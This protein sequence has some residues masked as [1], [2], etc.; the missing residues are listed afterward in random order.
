MQS[1]SGQQHAV[2]LGAGMAGLL[3]AR[4]L[5]DRYGLVTVIERDILPPSA[6]H[7]RGVSQGRHGH[8]LLARGIEVL[9]EL[10]PGFSDEMTARGGLRADLQGQTR[11]YNEGLLL[12]QAP[13]GLDALLGSRP[14]LE[15]LV[16]DRLR[17]MDNIR[18]TD[19][20]EAVGL[21]AGQD[22][23]R[24]TGLRVVSGEPGSEERSVSADLVV[25]ATGRG[26][27]GPVWLAE[28]GYPVPERDSVRIGLRY[29]TRHFRRRPE[30]VDGDLGVIVAVTDDIRR[31][32]VMLAQENDRWLVT[33]HGYLDEEPPLD[34]EGF[35]DFAARL[36]VPD[37]HEVIRDAEPI[38]EAV[39]FRFPAGTRHH[40]ERLERFPEGYLV[41]GDAMCSF[42]PVYAQG[43]TV[44]ALEAVL[45]RDCLR[46]GTAKLAPRF[47]EQAA[48]ISDALWD[49][50]VGGDLRYPEVEGPRTEQLE[51]VHAFM[52][53]V[54]AAASRDPEVGRVV[55]RLISLLE[56][57]EALM[58]PAFVQR[59]MAAAPTDSPAG[60]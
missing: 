16:R 8:S 6:G 54:H 17:A 31:G 43:M 60:R 10:F 53:Q 47:F 11:W 29:A 20:C 41:V 24:V 44:A 7:R 39:A 45:L 2:V 48:R 12:R 49:V 33:V 3:A 26:A 27:R 50:V 15:S 22:G 36:A 23:E 57:P 28:L 56:G 52:A 14:L 21:I 55:V 19:G 34:L 38:G 40:Y 30:D 9:E 18:F 37:I 46:D 32:G 42:N 25:D 35:R 4:V 51:Q 1:Q 59:V 5:A 13:I 58:D